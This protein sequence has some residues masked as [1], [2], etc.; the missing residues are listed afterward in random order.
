MTKKI[1]V[2]AGIALG[3]LW[4]TW[5]SKTLASIFYGYTGS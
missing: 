3:V 4:L 5:N 1:L 2:T